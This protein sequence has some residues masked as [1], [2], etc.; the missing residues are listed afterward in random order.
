MFVLFNKY[1]VEI[2]QDRSAAAL[3]D[4]AKKLWPDQSQDEDQTGKGWDIE[5]VR[6]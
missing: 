4:T 6:T 2:C 3:A 1:G 5:V